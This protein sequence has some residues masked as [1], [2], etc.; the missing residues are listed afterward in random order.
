MKVFYEKRSDYTLHFHIIHF[1][2]FDAHIHESVEIIYMKEGTAHAV[3]GGEDFQL[4]AGDFFVVFP[5]NVHYYYSYEDNCAMVAIIPLGMLPEFREVLTT[6]SLRSPILHKVNPKAT[7]LL[8]ILMNYDG[9]YKNEIHRGM[10]LAIFSMI[11]E[12]AEFNDGNRLDGTTLESILDFCETN[13]KD[14]IS[15][16]SVAK[17]LNLSE[18][19]IS[20]LFTNKIRINFRDYINSLRLQTSL[21]LLKQGELSITDIA[22]ES[23][24]ETI[25]TFNRAFRKKFGV[26]PR[27]YLKRDY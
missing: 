20:H 1:L 12:N 11:M 5:N 13:Y 22:S 15:L 18:S 25:R 19:H 7:E 9:K 10:T 2:E 8:E 26:S 23:G 3:A 27:E 16:N 6:K 14:D 21:Q 24:F 4:C 17:S